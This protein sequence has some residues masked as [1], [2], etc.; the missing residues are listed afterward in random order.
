MKFA[1]KLASNSA[2]LVAS[3]AR[4][5]R[6]LSVCGATAIATR[7]RTV[8]LLLRAGDRY[9]PRR[10]ERRSVLGRGRNLRLLKD[11]A[12]SALILSAITSI[13]RS[14]RERQLLADARGP[15]QAPQPW[16]ALVLLRQGEARRDP[17]IG[18]EQ[19]ANEIR[20]VTLLAAMQQYDVIR[21][22]A[23]AVEKAAYGSKRLM[24]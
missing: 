13:K 1:S 17:A 9:L 2:G 19:P 5:L 16:R 4:K 24:I 3:R 18:A 20:A 6:A 8:D 7:I 10:F 14:E 22:S 21:Q 12:S 11:T 15:M 23:G